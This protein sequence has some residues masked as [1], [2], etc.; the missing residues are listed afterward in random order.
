MIP[1]RAR[2]NYLVHIDR[3]ADAFNLG[4]PQLTQREIPLDQPP[5]LFSDGDA[6]GSGHGLH[7]RGKVG[8]VSHGRIFRVAAGMDHP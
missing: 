8:R 4:W 6:A 7:P 2:T 3:L 5:T 1:Q